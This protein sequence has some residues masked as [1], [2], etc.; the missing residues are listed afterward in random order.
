M[1]VDNVERRVKSQKGKET[2]ETWGGGGVYEEVL[3]FERKDNDVDARVV[4]PIAVLDFK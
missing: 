3:S 4:I 1:I 2:A